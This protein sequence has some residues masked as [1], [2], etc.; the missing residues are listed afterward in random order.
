LPQQQQQPQ[1]QLQPPPMPHHQHR[2][3]PLPPQLHTQVATAPPPRSSLMSP[4][5]P[6]SIGGVDGFPNMI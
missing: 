3:R 6:Q 2:P 4:V 1:I 5:G